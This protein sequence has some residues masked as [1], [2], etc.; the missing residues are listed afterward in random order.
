M[1]GA[2]PKIDATVNSTKLNQMLASLK[3]KTE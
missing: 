1:I 2:K 3:N